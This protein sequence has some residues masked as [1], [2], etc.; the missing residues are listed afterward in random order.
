MEGVKVIRYT[1]II[2]LINMKPWSLEINKKLTPTQVFSWEFCEIFENI[3]FAEHLQTT[4]FLLTRCSLRFIS[5]HLHLDHL[6][7]I[8]NFGT[9]SF[10]AEETELIK[11]EAVVRRCSIKTLFLKS[12]QN[13]LENACAEVYF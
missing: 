10:R 8:R 6:H 12:S 11:T 2:S 13:L 3:F 5:S 4:A 1:K 9:F 7:L